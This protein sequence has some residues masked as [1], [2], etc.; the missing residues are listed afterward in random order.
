MGH[1]TKPMYSLNG[2]T[3]AHHSLMIDDGIGDDEDADEEVS[4]V[5]SESVTKLDSFFTGNVKGVVFLS[6]SPNEE[7]VA[8]K[9]SCCVILSEILSRAQI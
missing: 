1:Y 2:R 9:T 7:A 3:P 5:R 8:G 4:Q 6:L